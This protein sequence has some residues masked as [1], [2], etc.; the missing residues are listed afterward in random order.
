MYL[1]SPLGCQI[2]DRPGLFLLRGLKCQ[3]LG[4]M[5]VY[6]YIHTFL[7]VTASQGISN[8]FLSWPF[9]II[10]YYPWG[11]FWGGFPYFSPPFGATLVEL[12]TICRDNRR[13]SIEKTQ[14]WFKVRVVIPTSSVAVEVPKKKK[15]GAQKHLHNGVQNGESRCGVISPKDH[16]L[17]PTYQDHP[18]APTNSICATTKF[19]FFVFFRCR[20]WHR[21]S[22]KMIRRIALAMLTSVSLKVNF[23]NSLLACVT[24]KLKTRFTP[25]KPVGWK[26][27]VGSCISKKNVFLLVKKKVQNK[28]MS[29]LWEAREGKCKLAKLK[30]LCQLS[31][32]WRSV[33]CDVN[34][35][36]LSD[37]F[38][39]SRDLPEQLVLGMES[40]WCVYT[41]FKKALK[42]QMDKWHLIWIMKLSCYII[43][44]HKKH[45][46]MEWDNASI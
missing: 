9:Q 38:R 43:W 27:E 2:S 46:A 36:L 8:L 12:A 25:L 34:S 40:R 22:A 7:E 31:L 26:L 3:T 42:N 23:T 1:D 4:F 21:T 16:L 10:I 45:V 5:Y 28:I 13:S 35:L 32:W 37:G 39:K 33:Y 11:L 14:P 44:A 29:F 17:Q 20:V 6:K 19:P 41:P 18:S 24:Y 15:N 30:N